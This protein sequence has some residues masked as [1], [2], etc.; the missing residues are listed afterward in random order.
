MHFYAV[1]I[2]TEILN[3]RREDAHFAFVKTA[4]AKK[5]WS[6]HASLVLK[7][8]K[9]LITSTF[10]LVK[11]DPKSI[12][13]SF[14]GIGSTP[15]DLTREIASNVF[16]GEAPVRHT[17]FEADIIAR[18]AEKAYP[19]RIHMADIP[20]GSELLPNPV[21]NMSGFSLDKRLFF[22]PGFPE[23]AHPMV[24]YA[25]STYIPD[26]PQTYRKTLI[27]QCS[28]NDI[29]PLMHEL[30]NTIELSC[31]PQLINNV[32]NVTLSLSGY[33]KQVVEIEFERFVYFL[34]ENTIAF[35]LE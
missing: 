25:L 5:G 10:E 34:K 8:E 32:A 17:S 22:M 33:D 31:L 11:N 29:N 35:T 6:L 3:G 9:E 13:F 7:D 15:D 30:P 1:I 18:F 14:G 12:L 26:A 23:M 2:G 16:T 28:E 27:A 20:I 4:L 21:N 19:H 24:E